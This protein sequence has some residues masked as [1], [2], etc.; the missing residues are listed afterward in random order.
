M[1]RG[2]QGPGPSGWEGSGHIR[3]S[4]KGPVWLGLS[5]PWEVTADRAGQVRE[6]HR[7]RGS[8]LRTGHR[9]SGHVLASG[10]YFVTERAHGPSSQDPARCHAGA[11]SARFGAPAGGVPRWGPQAPSMWLISSTIF[12]EVAA[13]SEEQKWTPCK[14]CEELGLRTLNQNHRLRAP[15]LETPR[16][17]ASFAE[18]PSTELFRSAG[19]RASG[20]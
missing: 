16:Q 8:G 12:E 9:G 10:A 11:G 6:S 17:E 19:I 5:G 3:G 18:P 2:W 15:A 13:G 14:V 4:E 1:R 7:G 20:R